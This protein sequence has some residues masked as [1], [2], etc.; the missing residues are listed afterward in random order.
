MVLSFFRG[1]SD[2]FA[3]VDRQVTEMV[4][5][6]RHAYD[7]AMTAL[8][9]GDDIESLGDDVRATDRQVNHLEET[10]RRE[11]VVHLAVQGS[12]D[13]A[14]VL[15]SLLV[16]KKLERVG[17]QTKNVFD[18]AAQGVRFNDAPDRD[19][20]E[21]DRRDVSQMFG[22][23][24]E[25]LSARDAA[26]IADYTRRA[27]AMMADY[28]NRVNTLLHSQEPGFYAVPRAMLA[29]YLK[30]V[31]ANLE[32]SARAISSPFDRSGGDLDE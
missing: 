12:A 3:N 16:V 32:G 18:L 17:D 5:A 24:I 29:R 7:V 8:I 9:A 21:R 22:D 4:G 31:V 26:A 19:V 11:L 10:V 20:F 28:D 1:D 25:V 2:L 6:C 15:T 14:F 30:R 13:I 23:A 27:D